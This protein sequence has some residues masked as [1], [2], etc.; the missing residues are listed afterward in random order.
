MAIQ[1]PLFLRVS[2]LSLIGALSLVGCASQSELEQAQARFEQHQ[3]Q[4]RALNE[5]R[6]S[7]AKEQINSLPEWFL[8][9]PQPDESGIYGV[10]VGESESLATALR[11]SNLE[12]RFNVA[13]E[14]SLALSA[15]ETSIGSRDEEYRSIVNTFVDSVDMSGTTDVDR[16]IQSSPSGYRIYTLLKLPYPG[17]N[18]AVA[19]MKSDQA[20]AEAAREEMERSYDRLMRRVEGES[21]YEPPSPNHAAVSLDI[22]NIENTP[23]EVLVQALQQRHSQ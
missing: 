18:S 1:K 19:K 14:I 13:S 20:F 15:E 16:R 8:T 22:E 10:G 7:E 3:A 6:A 12:A 9:K 5:Q 21:S 11:K 2:A 4:Q 17:M 23:D